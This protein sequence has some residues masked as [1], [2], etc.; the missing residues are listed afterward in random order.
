MSI[1]TNIQKKEKDYIVQTYSRYPVFLKRGNGVYL[2]DHLNK[3]YLDFLSGIAVNNL[4]YNHLQIKSV[5]NTPFNKLVHTSNL[6]YTEPQIK[7]A[8]KLSKLT[9]RGRVFFANSGAEANEA[10]LKL[11]RAYGNQFKEPRKKI[12]TLKNSFHG[13]TLATVFATAQKKYQKGFKPKVG[14][15]I[16][17]EPNKPKKLKKILTNDVSAIFV[18]LIQ[19]EGGINIL[20]KDFVQSIYLLCKKR[21]ILFM[22]DEVQTGFGRTGQLFAFQHYQIV[23]DVITLGKAIANGFPM[24]VMIAKKSFSEVL[25]S[26]MHASTFGGG[27]FISQIAKKVLDIISTKMFINHVNK[28]S[29][30]FQEK[31]NE[32]KKTYPFVQEVRGKGLMLGLKLKMDGQPIVEK[33]LKRG[34]ITNCVQGNILRFLPPLIIQK[35]HINEAVKK[36]HYVFKTL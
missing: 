20:D 10:A 13:R 15:Y 23:P 2:W 1:L 5:I 9:N 12:V 25:G 21:K 16:Y 4:G 33:L 29:G 27:Y 8:E 17:L 26:G 36:L 24:G 32:I 3:K 18:E 34:L 11:A 22:V 30:Y 6:F 31:L 28:M 35:H 19:G 7:L 14:N